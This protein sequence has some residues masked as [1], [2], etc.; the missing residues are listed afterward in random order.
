MASNEKF[1]KA[2]TLIPYLA[3]ASSFFLYI[4]D[5]VNNK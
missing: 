3:S 5:S 1:D 2:L 4:G